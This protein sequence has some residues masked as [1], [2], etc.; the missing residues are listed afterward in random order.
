MPKYDLPRGG[1]Y[2]PLGA[3]MVFYPLGLQGL[4][5]CC[6]LLLEK[7]KMPIRVFLTTLGLTIFNF[8]IIC[9][10]IA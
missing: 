10:F 8:V 9:S 4:I 1:H 3:S 7:N 5:R 6:Y 2:A